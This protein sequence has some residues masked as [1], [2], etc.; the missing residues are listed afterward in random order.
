VHRLVAKKRNASLMTWTITLDAPGTASPVT[1]GLHAMSLRHARRAAKCFRQVSFTRA[2]QLVQDVRRRTATYG[3]WMRRCSSTRMVFA[4]AR[5]EYGLR[6]L[7]RRGFPLSRMLRVQ[8]VTAV[9]EPG[10]GIL[11]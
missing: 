7:R 2:Y 9:T 6:E 4:S 11:S 3:P 10:D 8:R 1:E 5:C